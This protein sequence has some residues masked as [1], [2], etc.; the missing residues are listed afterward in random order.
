MHKALDNNGTLHYKAL[1][2][3]DS[4]NIN[5]RLVALNDIDIL[6]IKYELVPKYGNTAHNNMPIKTKQKEYMQ[7]WLVKGFSYLGVSR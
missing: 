7:N 2:H 4:S 6:H 1:N 3:N 5:I